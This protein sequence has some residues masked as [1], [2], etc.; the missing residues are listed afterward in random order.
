MSQH[1]AKKH[2]SSPFPKI[3]ILFLIF[4]S[5]F[6]YFRAS[7]S[8]LSTAL[9]SISGEIHTADSE[10]KTVEDDAGNKTKIKRKKWSKVPTLTK[11]PKTASFYIPILSKEPTAN[12]NQLIIIPEMRIYNGKKWE[13]E[14]TT[15]K[16]GIFNNFLYVFINCTDKQ[17]DGIATVYAKNDSKNIWQDD[18]IE[19][20]MMKDRDDD[21]Y[22][23][24]MISPIGTYHCYH[25]ETIIDRIDK[26]SELE[27]GEDFI[28]PRINA[29]ISEKGY[30]L[31][32]KIALQNIGITNTDKTDTI[33]L[34]MIR[35]YRELYSDKR[36]ETQLYPTHIYVDNRF[37]RASNHN[38]K[39]FQ[40]VKI[41]RKR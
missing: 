35:N 2:T 19:I 41:I 29:K 7:I 6:I 16:M 30:N 1:S 28:L 38:R 17:P 4:I 25:W 36:V 21:N 12:T 26:G 24:Y 37:N 5:L 10:T 13:D 18:S 3:C 39:G 20:F 8:G 9:L 34:N 27:K 23:Q 11:L 31:N 32:I 15:V 33:L 40:P 14:T 22:C